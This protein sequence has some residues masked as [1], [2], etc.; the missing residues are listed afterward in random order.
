L[1]RESSRTNEEEI[2]KKNHIE[3]YS[4]Y[5]E[6]TYLSY[7]GRPEIDLD[8]NEKLVLDGHANE[9]LPR[10]YL[11]DQFSVGSKMGLKLSDLGITG[12]VCC[13]KDK[14]LKFHFEAYGIECARVAIGDNEGAKIL[15]YLDSAVDFISKH[16]DRGGA[17][18]VHCM[19]GVSRSAT[20][21]I[22]CLMKKFKKSRDEAYVFVK[23]RRRILAP[24][25]GF[26]QQLEQFEAILAAE[27]GGGARTLHTDIDDD[28]CRASCARFNMSGGVAGPDAFADASALSSANAAIA[29]EAAFDF[30]LSRGMQVSDMKWMRGLHGALDLGAAVI[31]REIVFGQD[32]QDR[33][34]SDFREEHLN[35][36][37]AELE[38][39][40]AAVCGNRRVRTV[41]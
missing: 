20:V 33:W 13:V 18:L 35:A 22:A 11:G 7:S 1:N 34:G 38:A 10:L 27:N 41:K 23:S 39:T 12:I 19:Q 28:W 32:F 31:P 40:S 29:L 26:W 36:M 14:E 9:I 21:M 8:I 2:T 37:L 15:P 5:M 25:T 30:V 3:K 16:H 6:N 4:N 24:N 17:V